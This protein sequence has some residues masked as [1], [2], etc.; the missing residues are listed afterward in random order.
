MQHVACDELFLPGNRDFNLWC[1]AVGC[2]AVN[3]KGSG[4]SLLVNRGF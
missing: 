4:S 3:S 1:Y 2:Q